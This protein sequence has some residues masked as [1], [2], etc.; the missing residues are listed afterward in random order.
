MVAV[1]RNR[2]SIRIKGNAKNV[3]IEDMRNKF[4]KD[5]PELV[6][7]NLNGFDEGSF[8]CTRVE[9]DGKFVV[10]YGYF[11]LSDEQKKKL[12]AGYTVGLYKIRKDYHPGIAYLENKQETLP[13]I[14]NH[15]DKKVMMYV[16]WDYLVYGQ[17]DIPDD[18]NFNP[19]FYD[20]DVSVT[21]RVPAFYM[22]KYEVTNREYFIF[23]QKT[24]REL[25]EEWKKTG[26]YPSGKDN[27]P[28]ILA[29]YYDAVEYG[30]WTGKR[31]PTEF[32][33]ELAARGGLRIHS[34]GSIENL[35]ST[36][37]LYPQ[38]MD[39]DS[40]VCNSLESKIGYTL[41]VTDMRDR[42]PYGIY[43][44]CGNAREWT[45]SWYEPYPGHHFKKTELS[46]R[47]FKVIRGGSYS[48]DKNAVRAD[49]RDYGGFPTLKKDR[50]AGFRLVISAE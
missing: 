17:G 4:L 14:I 49:I 31:L 3:R 41:P 48:Q 25:P 38:G 22:D 11:K 6:M 45:D 33:W 21:K 7:K 42:S 9:L 43:G 30:R 12:I 15:I 39:F 24:G 26:R 46:G 34:N 13:E 19:Y 32:E 16:P 35:R 36:P 28:V 29:S 47:Q 27:N 40:S 37:P 10:L 20:R 44:L 8:T 18:D 2:G 1:Q 23:C 50:S 5:N